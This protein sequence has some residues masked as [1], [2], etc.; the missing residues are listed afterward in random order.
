MKAKNKS[1]EAIKPLFLFMQSWW[2]LKSKKMVEEIEK[3]IADLKI[4]IKYSQKEC[5]R[6]IGKND[7]K[8]YTHIGKIKSLSFVLTRLDKIIKNQNKAV[9]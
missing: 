3:L 4:S 6:A 9:N 1:H 2:Q 8:I 5:E 7:E